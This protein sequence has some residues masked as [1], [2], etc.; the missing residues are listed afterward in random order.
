MLE[1]E[2]RVRSCV[3][4]RVF[5]AISDFRVALRACEAR[6]V[7]RRVRRRDWAS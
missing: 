2:T 4:V 5:V 1:A 3:S 6:R 7:W